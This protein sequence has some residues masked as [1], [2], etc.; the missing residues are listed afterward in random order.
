[1]RDRGGPR[2]SISKESNA[3]KAYVRWAR[4]RLQYIFPIFDKT[5]V[6]ARPNVFGF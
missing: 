4:Y 2:L 6:A 5:V 3:G 1:M